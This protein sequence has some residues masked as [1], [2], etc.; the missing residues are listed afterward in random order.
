MPEGCSVKEALEMLG[1]EINMFPSPEAL[2]MPC[3]TGGCWSC[4]LDID[5]QLKPAC[6]SKVYQGMKIKTD[7]SS[8]TPR[9]TANLGRSNCYRARRWEEHLWLRAGKRKESL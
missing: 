4:S 2:F 8:L 9:T 5:G 3:Q 1:F 6:S 7:A